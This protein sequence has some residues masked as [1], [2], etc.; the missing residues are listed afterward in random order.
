[1][2]GEPPGSPVPH[3][4]TPAGVEGVRRRAEELLSRLARL[5]RI[6]LPPLR[7]AGGAALIAGLLVWALGP[8]A[9]WGPTSLVSLVVL[10][11][12][13]LPALRLYLHARLLRRLSD[14]LPA[15]VT[16]TERS[17]RGTSAHLRGIPSRQA[18]RSHPGSG[19]RLRRAWR[20]YREEV[21]PLRH[22]YGDALERVSAPVR[23]LAPPAL[24]LT[25]AA[26][27]ATGVLVLLVPV[28]LL[29]RWLL[30]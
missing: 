28:L 17:L 27:A 12:L 18:A 24:L 7:V 26:L 15:L 30:G 25:A 11:V 13:L 6:L 20:L 2:G 5:A 29:V 8:V 14:D 23:A 19:G 1:M 21:A 16:E 4:P 10:V 3:E 22:V 9:R